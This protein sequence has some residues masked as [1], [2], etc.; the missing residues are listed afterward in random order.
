LK[1]VTPASRSGAFL[2][3]D[4]KKIQAFNGKLLVSELGATN[5][6]EFSE[7]TISVGGALQTLPTG[8]GGEFYIE[9]VP[10]G[11]YSATANFGMA[12]CKFELLFPKSDEMFVD[13]GSITCASQPAK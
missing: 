7:I 5:P 2:D 4:P 13:L 12:F 9:N 10:S 8:R 11:V 6:V 1:K 3:F